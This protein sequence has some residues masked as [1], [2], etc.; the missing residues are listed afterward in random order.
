M[1]QA[2]YPTGTDLT[3]FLTSCGFTIPSG[4]NLTVEA[5]GAVEQWEKEVA[6]WP[7][8]NVQGDETIILDNGP[9]GWGFGYGYMGGGFGTWST[10]P[11][12]LDFQCGVISISSIVI[13]GNG[14]PQQTLVEGQDFDLLP[15]NAQRQGWPYSSLRLTNSYAL[16][17]L[18]TTD[19]IVTAKCGFCTQVPTDAWKA[20]LRHA[21]YGVA[22]QMS[23]SINQGVK[24][25]KA[26]MVQEEYASGPMSGSIQSVAAKWDEDWHAAIAY[27]A[28]RTI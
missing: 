4:M 13:G 22:G 9:R 3:N 18:T 24:A 8:L 7:F 10:E 2:A 27:Y 6:W 1:P 21:A 25:Y 28:R 5:E 15:R 17:G 11:Q 23:L 19:I 14:N 16:L 20:I 12:V 26:G